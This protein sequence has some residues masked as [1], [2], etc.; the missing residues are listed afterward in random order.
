MSADEEK[1]LILLGHLRTLNQ[2]IQSPSTS[3]RLGSPPPAY[4][5]PI[6]EVDET[7]DGRR[8]ITN[9]FRLWTAGRSRR[10][11]AGPEGHPAGKDSNGVA[12]PDRILQKQLFLSPPRSPEYINDATRGSI[13]L[14]ARELRGPITAPKRGEF[15]RLA[16]ASSKGGVF[17]RSHAGCL[18]WVP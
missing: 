16:Q 8:T 6:R 1:R 10:T 3:K 2:R 18:P 9:E 5:S 12:L 4:S 17:A 15:K 14:A 11:A 13:H 7:F